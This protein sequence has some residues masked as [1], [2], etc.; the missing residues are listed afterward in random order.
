M[1]EA[2]ATDPFIYHPQFPTGRDGRHPPRYENRDVATA[3]RCTAAH[4]PFG[5][6]SAIISRPEETDLASLQP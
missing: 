4:D 6:D 5:G 1:S 3:R 2:Y